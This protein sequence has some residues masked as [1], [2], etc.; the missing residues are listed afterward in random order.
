MK[1]TRIHKDTCIDVKTVIPMYTSFNN[2]RMASLYH[3]NL[4]SAMPSLIASSVI[5]LMELF[6]LHI[7]TVLWEVKDITSKIIINVLK[8][9]TIELTIRQELQGIFWSRSLLRRQYLC[10][11]C[12]CYTTWTANRWIIQLLC[13]GNGHILC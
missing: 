10:L 1:I 2:E 7:W 4:C 6:Y 8:H 9:S 11:D 12:S 13:C 3:D 5:I